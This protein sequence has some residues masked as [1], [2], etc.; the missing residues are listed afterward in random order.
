VQDLDK[1]ILIS[2]YTHDGNAIDHNLYC[3]DNLIFQSNYNSGLRIL[4]LNNITTTGLEEVAFFDSYPANNNTDFQ[5][6]WSNYP[7]FP[8]GNI[9][10]SDIKNGLFVLKYEP[11]NVEAENIAPQITNQ[12]YLID[13]F[14]TEGTQIASI[15]SFDRNNDVLNYSITAGNTNDAFVIDTSTGNL[16]VSKSTELDSKTNPVFTLTI[17]VSDG[18]LNT[19]ATVTIMIRAIKETQITSINNLNEDNI[20]IYPNPV[21]NSLNILFS[22]VSSNVTII[23]L[24]DF[25]G[26]KLLKSSEELID[27]KEVSIN[28]SSFKKGIYHIRITYG[29]KSVSKKVVIQ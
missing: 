28:T 21:K 9:I 6:T 20:S 2:T 24:Y 22:N 10:L 15:Y 18:K 8:S 25:S 5:G 23:E 11:T 13:E 14:S 7:F 17:E 3:K 16:A 4:G 12:A 19:S 27:K 1:P 29:N 26:K